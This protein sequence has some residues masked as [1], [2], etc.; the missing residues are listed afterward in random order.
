[1]SASQRMKVPAYGRLFKP[2]AF[3]WYGSSFGLYTLAVRSTLCGDCRRGL[4]SS[5]KKMYRLH[6]LFEV[7]EAAELADIEKRTAAVWEDNTFF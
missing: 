7:L 6:S 4:L 5:W 2:G 3:R 1:M